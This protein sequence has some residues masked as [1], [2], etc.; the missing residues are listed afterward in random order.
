MSKAFK[1]KNF[2]AN[3]AENFV[4]SGHFLDKV[5]DKVPDKGFGIGTFGTGPS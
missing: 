2:F 3:F 1:G 5:G 4:G